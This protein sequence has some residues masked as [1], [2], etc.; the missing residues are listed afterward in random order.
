MGDASPAPSPSYE[1]TQFGKEMLKHF[2]FDP[3]WKNLNHGSF[4]T[5]PRAVRNKQREYQDLC[6]SA[7]D[8]FIRYTYPNLS[9]AAREGVAKILNCSPEA[10]VFVPNA[11]TGVNTVLRNIVWNEDGKDEILY[12]SQIYGACLKTIE[13]VYETHHNSVNPREIVPEYPLEDAD[14]VNL[15]KDAIKASRATG[16]RPRL[17]IYDAVSSLPGVRIPFE[18]LTAVCKSE[19]ILSLID[20]AHGIGHIPLDMLTL[21]PDFLVTNAHKWLFVPRGCAVFYVP[22]KN[23]P[24]MRS[25]LPT[26]HGFVPKT[27]GAY[28]M[29]LPPVT[30]SE[31]TNQFEFIGTIDTTNYLV[32]GEAIKWREEVCGGEKAIMDYN[33]K[34]AQEGGKLVAEILGTKVLDNESHSLTNCCL[35]N[36]LLSIAVGAEDVTGMVT[37]KE[38]DV[39]MTGEWLQHSLVDDHKTFLAI[40]LFQGQLWARLS[41]QIYL[42]ITDFHWAGETLKA[43]CERV[44][45]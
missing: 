9:D 36:V 23:Q 24:L 35:V 38:E 15:F 34:L 41:G 18:D 37:I 20:A 4:G 14:Y 17:A 45:K 26:S 25:S 43:L 19:G 6:E 2:S 13:Y 16:K 11:T 31:F 44:G 1:R 8:P 28:T 22:L 40:W 3:N 29:P 42:D 32:A 7:P 33:I 27:V 30:K 21:D 5:F 39:V 10:V 12:F